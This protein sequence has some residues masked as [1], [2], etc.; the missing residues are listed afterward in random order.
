MR[1]V[2]CWRRSARRVSRWAGVDASPFA[3]YYATT[4]YGLDVVTGT[5][6][7]AAFPEASFDLIVQ[8]DLLEHV[9]HPRRHLGETR[10]LL[11]PGGAVWLITPN[12]EANLRPLQSVARS[13]DD[14]D[15]TRLP[16]LDQGHLSFFDADHLWTLFASCGFECERARAIGVRRGLRALGYLPGQRRLART[17]ARVGVPAEPPAGVDPVGAG[18]GRYEPL[19]ARIDAEIAGRHSPW[20]EW[21]PYRHYHRLMKRLDSLPAVLGIGYD[22]DFWLRRS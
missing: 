12:G 5:L 22:F 9:S 11:R 20:R 4:R 15:G 1:S 7:D 8:K 18:G 17:V 6:E 2:S 21:P 14:E 3:T 16:L 10:R 19:A 13:G